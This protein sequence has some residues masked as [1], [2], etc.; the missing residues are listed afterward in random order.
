[1]I[2]GI[3]LDMIE[4]ERIGRAIVRQ[5]FRERVYA[6]AERDWLDT[7]QWRAESAAGRFAAKEAAAKALGTG[8][9]RVRWTDIEIQAE[10]TGRPRIRLHG[11]AERTAAKLGIKRMWVTI[12]HD[13][14]RA[15]ACVIAEGEGV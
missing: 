8:I 2:L 9:G 3:G 5:R 15:A 4:I 12:T 6:E 1:M 7:I 14:G 10:D 13:K 11:E